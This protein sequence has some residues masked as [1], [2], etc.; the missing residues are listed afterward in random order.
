ME[1][2][3]IANKKVILFKPQTY[4]NLSGEAIREIVNF[5]K[6][7]TQNMLIIYDDMDIEKG[8]IKVRLK[9]GP[10]RTQWNEI[11]YCKFKN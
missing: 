8:K 1:H 5:Y 7:E 11:S 10:G 4:M 2:G 3:Q 9:G 6:I